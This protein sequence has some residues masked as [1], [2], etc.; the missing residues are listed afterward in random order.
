MTAPI[1]S[2]PGAAERVRGFVSS[3]GTALVAIACSIGA[4][5][6][7]A[8]LGAP[9]YHS[10][11]FPWIAG[12]T[13]GL[14][15]YLALFALV[16]LGIWVRH[17]WRNRWSFLHAETRLRVHAA[18]GATTVVLVTGHLAALAADSYAGVGW[19]GALL[20]GLSHY[21]T[22]PV[23]LG[24]GA[25][26]LLIAVSATAALSGRIF[27]RPWLAVH[28][29]A[30]PTFAL[31][32]FHGVLSGTDTP[33]LRTAYVATGAF[34]VLLATT[35]YVIADRTRRSV[36][37]E[38]TSA[39]AR[40]PSAAIATAPSAPAASAGVAGVAWEATLGLV[41]TGSRSKPSGA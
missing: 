25:L 16:C 7:F 11:Y 41:T 37:S 38:T 29:I 14:A 17:P 18:L 34:V 6:L 2:K 19:G 8:V 1:Q 28:Q 4:G 20:P 30:T 9:T 23:A 24:V 40:A 3:W 31:V 26:Y 33:T 10:R 22:V 12:R 39:P 15:S 32:W 5:Y 21:R 36:R 27:G 13:L 35:R